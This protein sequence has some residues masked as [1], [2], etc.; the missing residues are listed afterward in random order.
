MGKIN[1]E[2]PDRR[3]FLRTVPMAAAAGF[4][5]MDGAFVIRANAENGVNS[6]DDKFQVFTNHEL[7]GEIKTLEA[8][9]ANK[10]IYQTPTF[11]VI[12]TVEKDKAAPEFEWHEHRDHVIH[13][14]DGATTYELGGT[15]QKA[16]NTKPGE[17]LAPTSEG[18]KTVELKKGDIVILQRGTPHRRITKGSVV[19]TLTAPM[20]S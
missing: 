2:S 18:A 3:N 14:L 6:P 10:T 19:L 7:E 4:V 1:I 16:H 8:S 5:L 20:T 9:P 12:L 11:E 17:W 13:I 15:P